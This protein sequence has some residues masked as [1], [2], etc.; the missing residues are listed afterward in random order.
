MYCSKCTVSFNVNAH[1]NR[2]SCRFFERYVNC[3]VFRWAKIKNPAP[4]SKT[5]SKMFDYIKCSCCHLISNA[6]ISILPYQ[7]GA[8][9][10]TKPIAGKTTFLVIVG[11][12]FYSR[13][14]C[15][16]YI[17]ASQE[18][19]LYHHY[20]Y[21]VRREAC[22]KQPRHIFD[23]YLPQWSTSQNLKQSVVLV[24]QGALS[25]LSNGGQGCGFRSGEELRAIKAPLG[26]L[27][28]I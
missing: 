1:F 22:W 11:I 15:D 6:L 27:M 24:T 5:V 7:K 18:P 21:E 8:S 20:E 16:I 25:H 17:L 12:N 19:T 9:K 13:S 10:H 14:V 4:L 26:G 28:H 23:K 3:N 2:S